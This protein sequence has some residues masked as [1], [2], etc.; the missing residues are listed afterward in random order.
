MSYR[1]YVEKVPA[2]NIP[3]RNFRLRSGLEKRYL[4]KQILDRRRDREEKRKIKQLDKRRRHE[5]DEIERK[6]RLE[7][8]K[9][10]VAQRKLESIRLL[11]ELFKLIA[12]S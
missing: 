6:I 12:V 2:K 10:V 3:A 8:R 11:G 9:L 1:F 4:E 5:E 7:E